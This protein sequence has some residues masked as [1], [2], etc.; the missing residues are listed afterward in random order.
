MKMGVVE[1]FRFNDRMG[2]KGYRIYDA[3]TTLH[4]FGEVA[5]AVGLSDTLKP[6]HVKELFKYLEEHGVKEL[7]SMSHG[8][9]NKFV[10]RGSRWGRLNQGGQ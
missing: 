10:K 1:P 9:Y 3:I 4:F 6:S 5:W 7:N 8:G 2:D